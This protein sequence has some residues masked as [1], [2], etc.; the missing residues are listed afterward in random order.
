[1]RVDDISTMNEANV[2]GHRSAALRGNRMGED[3]R[4]D[5]PL[6]RRAVLELFQANQAFQ[7]AY[8]DF[9]RSNGRDR[10]ALLALADAEARIDVARERV[11]SIQRP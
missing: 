6:L 1:M 2:Q 3:H 10:D 7:N 5:D 11:A 4:V 8:A 9:T